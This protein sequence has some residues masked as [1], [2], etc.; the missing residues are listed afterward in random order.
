M[1][2]SSV[3]SVSGER[4]WRISRSTSSGRFSNQHA[5]LIHGDCCWSDVWGRVR[6]RD[7]R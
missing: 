6:E 7:G 2:R 3:A 1:A 5:P 4:C